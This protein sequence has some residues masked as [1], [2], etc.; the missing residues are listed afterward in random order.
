MAAEDLWVPADSTSKKQQSIVVDNFADGE[1]WH[2]L[3]EQ[4]PPPPPNGGAWTRMSSK[5]REITDYAFRGIGTQNRAEE[6]AFEQGIG[7]RRDG[8]CM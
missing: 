6:D 5:N 8:S 3:G 2:L 4:V 1:C 7:E